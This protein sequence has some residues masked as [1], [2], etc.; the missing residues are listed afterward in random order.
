[1]FKQFAAQGQSCYIA[2]GDGGAEAQP[3][4]PPGD[5]PYLTIVGGTSLTTS[6][7]GGPWQ[8]ESAWVG[9][10]GG[11]STRYAIPSWQEG[12][13]MQINQGSTTMRNLPDVAMLADTVLFFVYK[14]GITG[15]VGG[16]S[17]AAPLWAGFTAL[18]NQQAAAQG[19]PP[20][21]FINP[22]V[23]ALGKGPHAAYAACFHDITTGN[24]FNSSSPAKYSA[25]AGYDL[26]TGWGTP[27][28]INMINFLAGTG[29][30]DF[31]L[32]ASQTGFGL[33]PGSTA[34]TI[35]SVFPLGGFGGL[36]SWSIAGLP[37]GV[38]ASF[39]LPSTTS[40][41]LLTLTASGLATQGTANVTITGTSGGLSH[42]ITLSLTMVPPIPGATQVSLSSIYNRTG[43]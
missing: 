4:F 21:G 13:N 7:A 3:V 5:D 26:C 14:N 35:L 32:Y 38:T 28:G 41:S 39:S 12:I 43:I 23:Y 22:P 16:T 9:S 8:S 1:T 10:S 27:N 11:V 18:V 24:N 31:T 17:A 2:S 19:K 30:N 40:T 37:A 25:C 42:A 29:T 34:T 36:V 20:T 15:T 33:T 6:G